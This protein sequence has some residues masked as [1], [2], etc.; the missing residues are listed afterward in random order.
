MK[1]IE[2]TEE[3]KTRLLEMCSVLFPEVNCYWEYEM[4][5]RGLK[6]DFNSVL[7][8]YYKDKNAYKQN[9]FDFNIHWFEFCMTHLMYKLSYEFSKIPN[10]KGRSIHIELW[11]LNKGDYFKK[12]P[13]DYLYEEFKKLKK[14]EK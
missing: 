2:L 5:G 7:A 9:L 10:V 4:Y 12:H 13:V 3:H 14:Y 1:E 11:E 8:V 6:Q